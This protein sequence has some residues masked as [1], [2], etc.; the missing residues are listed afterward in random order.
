MEVADESTSG[1]RDGLAQVFK[2]TQKYLMK[3]GMF[4]TGRKE[5]HAKE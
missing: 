1:D 2:N 4:V 5:G 3:L